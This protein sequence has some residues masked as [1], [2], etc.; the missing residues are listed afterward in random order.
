MKTINVN[1]VLKQVGRTSFQMGLMVGFLFAIATIFLQQKEWIC[2]LIAFV[3]GL[4]LF[5]SASRVPQYILKKH[6]EE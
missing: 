4:I 2:A 6:Y 5:L 1:E 3:F